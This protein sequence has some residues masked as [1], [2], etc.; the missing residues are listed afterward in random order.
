MIEV[1]ISHNGQNWLV[2]H[3]QFT[4]EA[5]TLEKLDAEV[6]NKLRQLGMLKKGEKQKVFMAFENSVIPQWIR[7]YAQHYFNR[8]IELNG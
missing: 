5:L 3:Q 6:E 4:A 7:Q 8:I 1:I 2:F